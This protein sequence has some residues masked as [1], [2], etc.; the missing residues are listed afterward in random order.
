LVI[1]INGPVYAHEGISDDGERRQ[2]TK[3]PSKRSRVRIF[4]LAIA[5]LKLKA[6]LRIK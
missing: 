6:L 3:F 4:D 1:E 5:K 2:I